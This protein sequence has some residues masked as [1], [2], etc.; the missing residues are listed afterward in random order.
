MSFL[1]ARSD[2]TDL[3]ETKLVFEVANIYNC[4][5]QQQGLSKHNDT[6]TYEHSQILLCTVSLKTTFCQI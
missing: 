1:A 4:T 3:N 2:A 6:V 5:T